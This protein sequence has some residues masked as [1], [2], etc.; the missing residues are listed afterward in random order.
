MEQVDGSWHNLTVDETCETLSTS[1]AGLTTEE[2]SRRLEQYGPNE[3]RERPRPSFLMLLLAQFT[4]PLVYVLAAAAGISVVVGEYV[5]AGVIVVVIIV[6]AIIGYIQEAQA[7]ES[8]EALRQLASPTA[9]V[10]RDGRSREVRASTLVPGDRV[11][12]QTGDRVPADIRLTEAA[13]LR[14]D[15]SS[16]TGESLPVDKTTS[17]VEEAETL[18]DR[19][20]IAHMGS[21]VVYG[22]GSGVVVETGMRT[23]MGQIATSLGQV[24]QEDTPLQQALSALSRNLGIIAIVFSLGIFVGGLLRGIPMF[25]ILIFAIAAAVSALPEGLPVV[26]TIVLALGMRRMARRNAII[27]RLPAVETLGASTVVCTD[28][29]GT[30]TQNQMTV[31]AVYVDGE[32]IQVTGEG[33]RPQGE[34][35]IDGRQIAASSSGP[36]ATA[37]RIGA[38]CNDAALAVEGGRY[39]VLGDPTEGALLVL[40][41]KAGLPRDQLATESRRLDEIPFESERQYMATLQQT[42]G[43]PTAFVKGSPERVLSFA[44]AIETADGPRQLDQEARDGILEASEELAGRAL[45]LLALGYRTLPAGRESVSVEDVENDLVFVGLVGMVDPPREEARRAVGVAAQ[46]GIRVVMITGDNKL[47]AQSIARQL[48]LPQTDVL[49]G[50][51][52]N[53]MTDE[54]LFANVQHVGVYAR[55]EPQQ[56]LRIVTALKEHGEV[57]AMTGDGVNDAPAL[58]AADIGISMGITGTAVAKEASDMILADDN[59]ASIISAVEEGRVIFAN[60]RRVVFYL[61]STNG[62]ELFTLGLALLIGLPLPVTAVQILWINLVTDGL[63]DKTLGVEPGQPQILQEPPRSPEAGI[64]YP[65]MLYRLAFV[66]VFMSVGTLGLFVWATEAGGAIF[67]NTVAFTALAAF[68]WA[69][70][71]NAR[72][73]NR[74][75]FRIGFFSNRWVLI[76]IAASLLLQVV[77]VEVPALQLVFATT[78]LGVGIWLLVLGLASLLFFVEEIRKVVLPD[79]YSAGRR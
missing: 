57:V 52:L 22:R 28:K 9:A 70:A 54:D 15:E 59:F 46:A 29:T 68:Q 20:N 53:R 14:V 75:V 13:N 66:A 37:L 21:P 17:P 1:D 48:E 42:D 12:L 51:E 72:S 25:D 61:L 27:R 6:N 19:R 5:D 67:G 41:E 55:V 26:V 63:V 62:G 65:G 78:S 31:R 11:L 60:I 10:V 58:K 23:A 79:L 32:M 3:L 50:A 77:V 36:L 30:L 45:R 64:I 56:K 8:I 24:E 2:A 34:F 71:L 43:R 35:R 44:S 73:V 76:G 40:A 18:G 38:L 33:Y 39:V 49:T 16:L 69:N 4:N 7:E 74:P 47:T